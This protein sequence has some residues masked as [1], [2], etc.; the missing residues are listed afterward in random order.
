MAQPAAPFLSR[1]LVRSIPF[2]TQKTFNQSVAA[3]GNLNAA[4]DVGTRVTER[5]QFLSPATLP[6][7][8]ITNPTPVAA[9]GAILDVT[10]FASQ[11]GTIQ[12]FFAVD[13]TCTY[14]A[15]SAPIAVAASTFTNISGLRIT[16]RFVGIEY[17]NTA[18]VASTTE[19]GCFVRS[20]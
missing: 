8:M 4:F 9:I 10:L 16:A 13:Y 18:V 17:V 11:A 12:V 3:A 6:V 15:V 1:T 7:G 19:L 5:N 20:Q 14:R 2:T